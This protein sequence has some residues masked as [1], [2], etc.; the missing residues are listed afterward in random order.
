MDKINE[1]PQANFFS[2][3]D[4]KNFTYGFDILSLMQTFKGNNIENPYNRE[5]VSAEIKRKI[6]NFYKKS[7]L[8]YPELKIK[9]VETISTST[10]PPYRNLRRSA[11]NQQ[12]TANVNQLSNE[13]LNRFNT[14]A[15]MRTKPISQRMQDLFMEI[16]QLGNYTQVSWFSNLTLN[17]YIRLY[18]A[19]FEIWNY[20][21]GLSRETKLKICPFYGPFERIFQSPIYY[22]EITLEQIQIGCTTVFETIT[23]SGVDEDHRKL[24]AFHALSALTIV[25]TNAR[26]AMP[27]LYESVAY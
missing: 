4:S 24:G 27:W 6:T 15:N 20:R 12:I 8:L 26:Q 13:S 25:S 1:I 9:N 23:C 21:S 17:Q 14:L 10:S 2:F 19:L 7:C 5:K 16:D 18:R 11:Q 22:D 3:T